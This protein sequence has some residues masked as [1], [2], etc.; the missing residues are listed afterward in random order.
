MELEGLKRGV[1]LLQQSGIQIAELVTDRH[2]QVLKY[3]RENMP[4]TKQSVDVWHVS[5]GLKKKLVKLAREKDCGELTSWNRSINN[6]LYWVAAS[7]PNSDRQLMQEKWA[8]LPNHIHNQHTH[9]G[10]AFPACIHPPLDG[11]RKKKWLKE[12]TKVS[13]K[14]LEIL[15]SKQLLKDIGMLATGPQ[16]AALESFHA[17]LNHFAPKLVAFSYDGMITCTTQYTK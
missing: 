8:S 5:K 10:K 6:H 11:Q 2:P 15:Q 9:K 14:L 13:V 1:N 12:G 4:T 16:T 7:T 17:V 3:V